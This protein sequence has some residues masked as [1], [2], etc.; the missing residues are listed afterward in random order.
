MKKPFSTSW[1]LIVGLIIVIIITAILLLTRDAESSNS[2]SQNGPEQRTQKTP[3]PTLQIANIGLTSLADNE[4]TT[5]ATRDYARAGLRGFYLFGDKFTSND[6][7]INPN[8]E[9]ASLKKDAKIIAA[10]DGTV[11]HIRQQ[12]ESSDYEVFL[13]PF[14]GSTWT[15]GYDHLVN[16]QVQ[17][18]DK[19][20]VG[21][22]LGN[23]SLQ[24][25]GLYRFEFQ[26]NNEEASGTVH[27]CPS[28][29]LSPG[30]APKILAELQ[31]HQD[32]WETI[33]K[34]ELYQPENQSPTGCLVPTLTPAQAEGR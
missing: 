18:G 12:S 24:N 23:P 2:S 13:Q 8:F 7:R 20:V 31:S 19:V 15:I 34:L 28:N 11:T 5:Q 3:E 10:I 29:L 32:A 6:P 9:F 16:L 27:H 17:T 4:V 1:I 30:T 26:V 21:D 33:T 22:V 25:N 14:A